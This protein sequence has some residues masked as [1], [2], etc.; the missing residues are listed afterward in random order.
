MASF[1]SQSVSAPS[2]LSFQAAELS[3]VACVHMFRSMRHAY[4]CLPHACRQANISHKAVARIF[5]HSRQLR[6]T[7][8]DTIGIR[9][10][11]NIE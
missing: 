4:I 11:R 7:C 2:S 6:R 3:A 8:A 1:R 9:S 5:S 10:A